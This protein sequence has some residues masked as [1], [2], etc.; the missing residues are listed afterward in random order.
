M[1]KSI[2]LL[3][4]LNSLKKQ[5]EEA[6]KQN[7]AKA[8]DN[9]MNN[10]KTIKAQYE[11]ALELEEEEKKGHNTMKINDIDMKVKKKAFA[12]LIVGNKNFTEAENDYINTLKD[13]AGSGQIGSEGAKGGYTIPEEFVKPIAEARQ[14]L[15]ELKNYCTV[16]NVNRLTGVMPACGSENGELTA[17]DEN[18]TITNSAIDFSQV[19]FTL[20]SYKDIIPVSNELLADTDVDLV[21]FINTRFAKKAV[22]AENKA[23]ITLLNTLEENAGT[24]YTDIIS[25]L[26]TKLDAAISAD[27]IIITNQ[28]GFD[29]LDTLV[30]N[31]GAPILTRSFADEKTALLRGHEIVVV[32]NSALATTANKLPFFVGSL[33][34]F[35]YF[36]AKNGVELAADSSAGFTSNTT[37]LRAVE[38]FDVQKV[39]AGAMVKVAITKE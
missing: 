15:I 29:Y 21:G 16:K 36:F 12:K 20:K 26:N 28:D 4:M 38:R 14:K 18:E 30:D 13:T 9:I 39:N 25:A 32:S 19:K 34:D 37:Y 33:E 22:N 23:I 27:A 11:A 35:A 6:N 17:F 3:N 10:A 2:E 8:F 7:D 5:A 31:N 24:T 1:K